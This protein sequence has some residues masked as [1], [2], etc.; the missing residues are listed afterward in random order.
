MIYEIDQLD[1]K[2]ITP[3]DGRETLFVMIRTGGVDA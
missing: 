2:L 3:V 1:A